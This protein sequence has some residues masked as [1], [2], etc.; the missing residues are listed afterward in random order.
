MQCNIGNDTRNWGVGVDWILAQIEGGG[1]VSEKIKE[2]S[3]LEES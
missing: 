2:R 3:P 1:R